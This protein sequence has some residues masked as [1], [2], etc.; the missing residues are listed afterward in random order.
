MDRCA[1][2]AMTRSDDEGLVLWRC[3]RLTR[4]ASS[5]LR[6]AD[7]VR[8]DGKGRGCVV[9]NGSD[10]NVHRGRARQR[11]TGLGGEAWPPGGEAPARDG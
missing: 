5:N 9:K 7:Q 1:S 4:S 3:R 2:L 10:N 8:N 6:F 11:P